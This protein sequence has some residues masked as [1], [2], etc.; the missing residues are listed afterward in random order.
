MSSKGELFPTFS[1]GWCALRIIALCTIAWGASANAL[2]QEAAP[3]VMEFTAPQISWSLE[4]AWTTNAPPH[5]VIGM[6]ERRYTSA[7]DSLQRPPPE[8]A[9]NPLPTNA[10]S[11][12]I[13]SSISVNRTD[14][15][16]S[17]PLVLSSLLSPTAEA[18]GLTKFRS[19]GAVL[20]EIQM[21]QS[22]DHKGYSLLDDG[23]PESFLY[24]YEATYL[25]PKRWL[26]DDES[27]SY[28]AGQT[29]RA[30]TQLRIANWSLAVMLAA[31]AAR[32]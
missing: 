18:R 17:G 12:P 19:Q 7:Y 22:L 5:L 11:G 15:R 31:A 28:E 9:L 20:P 25:P 14:K 3:T 1:L 10:I 26:A 8:D 16:A 2:A 24:G 6:L 29:P 30:L 27:V 32:R 23:S 4:G 21:S 13:G